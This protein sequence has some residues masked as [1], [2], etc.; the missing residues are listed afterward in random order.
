MISIAQ[1]RG[2]E[3]DLSSEAGERLLQSLI[4]SDKAKQ[5]ALGAQIAEANSLKMYSQA[6]TPATCILAYYTATQKINQKLQGY[7]RPLSFRAI[8]Y[9]LTGM[10]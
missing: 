5:F 4:M 10:I 1:V 6:I 3:V 8:I 2:Q 7:S 9:M